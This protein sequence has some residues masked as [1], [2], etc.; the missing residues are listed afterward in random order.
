M[1]AKTRVLLAVLILALYYA[2]LYYAALLGFDSL[3]SD[4]DSRAS[5]SRVSTPNSTPTCIRHFPIRCSRK[6]GLQTYI[7]FA[8]IAQPHGQR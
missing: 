5:V 4:S 2:A 7:Y 6:I 8:N 3:D 1:T